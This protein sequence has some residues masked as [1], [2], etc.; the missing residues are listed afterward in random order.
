MAL[1]R[2]ETCNLRYFMHL[3]HPV[4][5]APENTVKYRYG[6]Y[7]YRVRRVTTRRTQN[8][9]RLSSTKDSFSSYG[10][11]SISK[12]LKMTGLFCKRAL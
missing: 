12:L 8:E 10:L 4:G 9:S 11:A 2:K 3:R 1:L 5:L 6:K 7:R